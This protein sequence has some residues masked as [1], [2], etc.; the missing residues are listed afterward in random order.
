VIF[1]SSRESYGDVEKSFG[2]FGG[3]LGRAFGE[4][5]AAALYQAFN[6]TLESSRTELRRQRWDLS[7]NLPTDRDAYIQ[8]IGKSRWIRTVT[9]RV[10]PASSF[11]AA[12]AAPEGAL[13]ISEFRIRNFV[14]RPCLDLLALKQPLFSI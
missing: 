10:R 7:Y 4:A 11:V 3:A 2:V 6:N 1:S 12:L 14:R 5:G 8:A 9:V 13:Q